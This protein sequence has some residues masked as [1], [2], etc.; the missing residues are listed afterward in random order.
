MAKRL[1]AEAARYKAVD[2]TYNQAKEIQR[3]PGWDLICENSHGRCYWN[4]NT[5]ELMWY[6]N[7]SE[8]VGC[9]LLANTVI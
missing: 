1:P 8:Q 3:Q 4:K 2:I 9:Q 7:D 5:G 6:S